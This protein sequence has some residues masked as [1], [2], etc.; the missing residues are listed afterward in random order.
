MLRRRESLCSEARE[1]VHG[2]KVDQADLVRV[3]QRLKARTGIR[4][5]R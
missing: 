3:I 4:K 1:V 5:T 2:G